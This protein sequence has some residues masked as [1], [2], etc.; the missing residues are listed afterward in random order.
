[1]HLAVVRSVA[2]SELVKKSIFPGSTA[3]SAGIGNANHPRRAV[4]HEVGGTRRWPRCN[5]PVPEAWVALGDGPRA[6]HRGPEGAARLKPGAE[7]R[8]EPGGR[9]RGAAPGR[10]VRD[11]VGRARGADVHRLVAEAETNPPVAWG[12]VARRVARSGGATPV[13]G[14]PFRARARAWR[15]SLGRRSAA[16]RRRFAPGFRRRP[17]HGPLAERGCGWPARDM[18]GRAA[19]AALGRA[20]G[21]RS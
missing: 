15:R 21:W 9:A 14:C 19:G 2:G 12:A 6:A 17:L 10:R 7:P 8:A 20:C 3:V 4:G 11:G 16:S 5:T 1:V 13:L 18:I